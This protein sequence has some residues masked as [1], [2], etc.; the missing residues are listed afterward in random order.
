[1][2]SENSVLAPSTSDGDSPLPVS[3]S[4]NNTSMKIGQFNILESLSEE[5]TPDPSRSA[6]ETETSGN[7]SPADWVD[8]EVRSSD[9]AGRSMFR[10]A[11]EGPRS[12]FWEEM[13]LSPLDEEVEAMFMVS[14]MLEQPPDYSLP[15]SSANGYLI[16]DNLWE[17]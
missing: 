2:R 7:S 17:S 1:M 11:A 6:A 14:S 15:E 9:D 12:D 13:I 16:Y 4:P 5:A 3:P 8:N 10:G